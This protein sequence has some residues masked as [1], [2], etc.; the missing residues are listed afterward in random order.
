MGL[1]LYG[2]LMV[3][4]NFFISAVLSRTGPSSGP[5]CL[6]GQ[7]VES[8]VVVWS[9]YGVSGVSGNTSLL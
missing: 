4:V 2:S 3:V 8:D 1:S 5:G 9:Q 7:R 6:E